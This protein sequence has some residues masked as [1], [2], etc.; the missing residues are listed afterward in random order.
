MKEVLPEKDCTYSL[1]DVRN[2]KLYL[3]EDGMRSLMPLVKAEAQS[4]EVL[5]NQ[6]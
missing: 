6:I 4:L 3:F 5:L 2:E 1:L